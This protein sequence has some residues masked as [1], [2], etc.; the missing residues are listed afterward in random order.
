MSQSDTVKVLDLIRDPPA[1]NPYRHLKDRLLRM[2]ALTDYA[3]LEA[4]SN[5][6]LSGDMLPSA[7]MSKMLTLFPAD[8]QAYFFLRG[9][10]LQCLPSDVR[11]H[12]VHNRFLDRL[13][14]V[15]RT[16]KISESH[17]VLLRPALCLHRL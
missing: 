10:F 17:F 9:P 1:T 5:L 4:I 6:P 16:D 2:Y 14:L 11:A 8:H 3:S 13:S 7:L 12:L 15:L